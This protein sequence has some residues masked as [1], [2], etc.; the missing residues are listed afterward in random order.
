MERTFASSCLRVCVDVRSEALSWLEDL[1]TSV[2]V[3]ELALS[4]SSYE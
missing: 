1:T 3:L 4:I 2:G